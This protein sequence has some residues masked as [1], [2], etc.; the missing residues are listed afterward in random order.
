MRIHTFLF[1]FL[2]F[3]IVHNKLLGQNFTNNS[4]STFPESWL[5]K[6]QG[7]LEI[8][9]GETVVQRVPM[10]LDHAETDRSGVYVWALVYGED[11]EAGRRNYLLREKNKEMGHW[12][13][14]EQNSIF[15]DAYVLSNKLIS[16]FSVMGTEITSIYTLEGEE[17]VFEIIVNE[18][19]ILNKT[20]NTL[21]DGEEIPEV[22]NYAVTSYQ[23]AVL[24]KY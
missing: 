16:H 22:L 3:L 11:L 8:Y 9:K 10:Y 12:I 24:K 23:R 14:D 18:A 15:L 13:V 7:T 2:S 4:K 6:W 20:G 21:I 17:M 1:I 5:G 19:D